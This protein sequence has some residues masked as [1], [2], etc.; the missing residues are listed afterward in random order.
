MNNVAFNTLGNQKPSNYVSDDSEDDDVL[1]TEECWDI[2]D[3]GWTLVGNPRTKARGVQL[4]PKPPRLDNQDVRN[5]AGTRCNTLDDYEDNLVLTQFQRKLTSNTVRKEEVPMIVKTLPVPGEVLMTKQPDRLLETRV[6]RENKS[7]TVCPRNLGRKTDQRLDKPTNTS[8][9]L[10]DG[11]SPVKDEQDRVMVHIV[12]AKEAPVIDCLTSCVLKNKTTPMI[13]SLELVDLPQTRITG[14]F[15]QLAKEASLMDVD[16]TIPGC[17]DDYDLKTTELCDSADRDVLWRTHNTDGLMIVESRSTYMSSKRTE[18]LDRPVENCTNEAMRMQLDGIMIDHCTLELNM[19]SRSP[20]WRKAEPVSVAAESEVFTQVCSGEV[21]AHT[22]PL[23]MAEVVTSRVSALSVVGNDFHASL[24]RVVDRADRFSMNW[25]HILDKVGHGAGQLRAC[26]VPMEDWNLLSVIWLMMPFLMQ[27]VTVQTATFFLAD[28]REEV[29]DLL[30][31][32]DDR[33]VRVKKL[34]SQETA[35]CATVIKAIHGVGPNGDRWDGIDVFTAWFVGWVRTTNHE[36]E[37]EPSA[38]TGSPDD[39]ADWP[40]GHPNRSAGWTV[41]IIRVL[42]LNWPFRRQLVW[43]QY[44]LVCDCGFISVRYWMIMS[45]VGFLK[46]ISAAQDERLYDLPPGIQ[47]VI[48]LQ[49]LRP[50]AAVCKVMSTTESNSV[51]VITP[52]E[53]VPTGFHEILI[54]DMGLAEWPKVPMSDIGCLRLDWPP[55]LFTFVGRYQVE[56]ELMRKECRDQFEGTTSG[57]CTTCDKFIQNSLGRHVAM[58]HLDLAQ[59]WRCPVGWCPVWKSTSQDCVDHM[60]RAHNTPIMMKAG[61]LARWFPPW[62]V[63][64]EQW[65]SMSR[66]SVSGI[67]IDTFLFSRIG[68][69]LFHRYRVFD[70]FGSH[71]AF[72]TP[73]MTNLF[74]FLK[75]SDSEAIRRSHRRRAKELAVGLLPT[76]PVLRSVV[77]ETIRSGPAPQRTVVSRKQSANSDGSLLPPP[78][79]VSRPSGLVRKAGVREH[80]HGTGS[81]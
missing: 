12:P 52:D 79:D 34:F 38:R 23:V 6:I 7:V 18:N 65:H 80:G 42:G 5:Y 74:L 27:A 2:P 61:N 20:V 37:Y 28:E 48:G 51:R 35:M 45:A 58:Y 33:P 60:R 66:P 57:K 15:L 24:S 10:L 54:E 22:D 77:S 4:E 13:V 59:L 1:L 50:S 62:T 36:L 76:T 47:D 69:P 44:T 46:S 31:L 3:E 16:Q 64:R 26:T 8:T 14:G 32:R 70:R 78:G 56:L 49:A 73:Y 55:E 21:V 75:E 53:H 68:M 9:V 71:S 43:W 30:V 11:N 67:A 72:R 29:P 41:I 25:G 63:T 81:D 19:I 40:P 39:V 17:M